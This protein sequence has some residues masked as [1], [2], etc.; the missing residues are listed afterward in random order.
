MPVIFQ[1]SYERKIGFMIYKGHKKEF[2]KDGISLYLA[3]CMDIMAATPDGYYDLCICDPPYGINVAKMA[4]TQEENRPCKQK[5]GKILRVKKLSYKHGDWDK[6]P[7]TKEYFDELI[8][9][10][11]DQVIWGINH[12]DYAFNSDGRIKWDKHTPE[13]VSFNR[14]EYAYCS[15]LSEEVVFDFLWAGMC[16]GISTAYP[17]KQQGNKK[18]NEK[19]IHPTQKPVQLYKWL[20]KNYATP[21]MKIIDTHGGSFSSAIAGYDF[22]C[23]M[24]VCEIDEDYFDSGV[25]RFDNETR[26]LICF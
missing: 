12:Y 1:I 8:R 22:G 26:Q 20:L 19:R 11:K 17:T 21:D 18:L 9:I 13:G 5:N 6:S 3:D 23:E 15:L 16:Q 10:S 25:K 7:P 4:Y 14:Y 24:L 2:H